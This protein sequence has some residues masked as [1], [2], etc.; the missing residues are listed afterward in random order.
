[1]QLCSFGSKVGLLTEPPMVLFSAGVREQDKVL[2]VGLARQGCSLA[3]PKQLPAPRARG[4]PCQKWL[5]D[6][7]I[8]PCN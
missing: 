6:L 2:F 8:F 7:L 5:N 3:F 1:M 4:K